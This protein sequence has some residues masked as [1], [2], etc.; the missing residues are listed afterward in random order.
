MLEALS[1]G[2]AII[3][4]KAMGIED[5]ITNGENGIIVS[6]TPESYIDAICYLLSQENAEKLEKIRKNARQ[7]VVNKFY[8]QPVMDVM[9][10]IIQ[11]GIAIKESW[12][13]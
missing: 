12:N 13:N 3:A 4:A 8:I 10:P 2:Q 7:S 6:G 11:E 5:Y 9:L 1:L